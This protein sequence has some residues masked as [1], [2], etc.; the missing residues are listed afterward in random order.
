MR[1]KT[2][3]EKIGISDGVVKEW[4]KRG[5]KITYPMRPKKKF[6]KSHDGKLFT[7]TADNFVIP[8]TEKETKLYIRYP[9]KFKQDFLL[10]NIRIYAQFYD[11]LFSLILNKKVEKLE[12]RKRVIAFLSLLYLFQLTMDHH[13]YHFDRYL[14]YQDYPKTPVGYWWKKLK[15]FYFQVYKRKFSGK[16]PPENF[17]KLL[18][19]D[20]KILYEFQKSLSKK[21]FKELRETL[22]AI[23][24]FEN[25]QQDEAKVAFDLKTGENIAIRTGFPM[26][27]KL[28]SAIKQSPDV[29][30]KEYFSKVK[31]I[32]EGNPIFGTRKLLISSG[33]KCF[34]KEIFNQ[35]EKEIK[36]WL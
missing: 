36:R 24:I 22:K 29:I 28:Y 32:M 18:A 20:R 3:L 7:E 4:K 21:K 19:G 26:W 33:L 12:P 31:K 16:K 11:F 13:Y 25:T 35:F 30:K 34:D 10:K 8:L 1:D 2:I 5:L 17:L 14:V 6:F 15:D 9:R 23:K 27:N